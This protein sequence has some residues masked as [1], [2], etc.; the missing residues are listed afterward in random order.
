MLV[1]GVEAADDVVRART[2]AKVRPMNVSGRSPGHVSGKPVAD[3][4]F[5]E[6]G[7]PW[8]HCAEYYIRSVC[9]TLKLELDPGGWHFGVC[10]RVGNP[11]AAVVKGREGAPDTIPTGAS[12]IPGINFH[13]RMSGN[14][15]TRWTVASMQ[16]SATTTVWMRTTGWLAKAYVRVQAIE[17][18]HRS[19]SSSSFRAGMTT[20]TVDTF[21]SGLFAVPRMTV[22]R[23][24]RRVRNPRRCSGRIA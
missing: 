1:E 23:C 2:N 3:L 17:W 11:R 10:I 4:M 13:N 24:R 9:R 15:F 5:S 7:E 12:D 18:T 22:R 21:T 8:P 14:C 19:M 20:S 6:V 16:R